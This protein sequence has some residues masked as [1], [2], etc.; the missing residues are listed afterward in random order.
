MSDVDRSTIIGVA[1]PFGSTGAR[2]REGRE[3]GSAITVFISS[4][5]ARPQNRFRRRLPGVE[6]G[7]FIPGG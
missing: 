4:P 5:P 2:A 3:C 1:G 7:R 6:A